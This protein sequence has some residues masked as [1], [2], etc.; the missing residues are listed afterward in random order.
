MNTDFVE[1][2]CELNN[3]QGY[4]LN[5]RTTPQPTQGNSFEEQIASMLW[6]YGSEVQ[7][8]KNDYVYWV[9]HFITS[10][11]LYEWKLANLPL[12]ACKKGSFLEAE[13][14]FGDDIGLIFT[15]LAMWYGSI[16]V[17]EKI[18]DQCSFDR[19]TGILRYGR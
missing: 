4:K 14:L 16:K 2:L 6:H 7:L 17:F 5:N 10:C 3:Y 9:M 19:E 18:R 11:S 1:L 12:S 8:P 13:S 15:S